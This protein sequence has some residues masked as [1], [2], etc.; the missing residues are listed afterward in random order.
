ML[1]GTFALYDNERVIGKVIEPERLKGR[2]VGD[3]IY[4]KE[5]P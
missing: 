1:Q 4:I 5:V 2:K 3:I